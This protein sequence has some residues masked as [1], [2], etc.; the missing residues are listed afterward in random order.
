MRR[1]WAPHVCERLKGAGR[2]AGVAVAGKQGLVLLAEMDGGLADALLRKHLAAR[3]AEGHL[4][5]VHTAALI[6]L[7]QQIPQV[8]IHPGLGEVIPFAAGQYVDVQWPVR[9]LA[10]GVAAIPAMSQ[11]HGDKL[12]LEL[13]GREVALDDEQAVEEV[14]ARMHAHRLGLDDGTQVKATKAGQQFGD[15]LTDVQG[16]VEIGSNAT[17]VKHAFHSLGWARLKYI[18]SSRLWDSL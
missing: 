10:Q 2:G 4:A 9:H 15:G 14:V 5:G 13:G 18:R 12:G 16:G 3:Q 8:G 6:H 1:L 17:E 11:L 7:R